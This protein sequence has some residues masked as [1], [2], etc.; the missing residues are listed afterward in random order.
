VKP[1][2]ERVLLSLQEMP[3]EELPRFLGDLEE[4]R[5]T[6]MARITA[7]AQPQPQQDD[8]LVDIDEAAKR[9]AMS[10]DYL[11]RHADEFPFTRRIGRNLRFSALGIAKYIKQLDSKAAGRY[12]QSRR[13]A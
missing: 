3:A 5:V 2:L 6:A 10:K 1:D 8:E 9:L 4:I 13:M 12:S 7:P 11:Y